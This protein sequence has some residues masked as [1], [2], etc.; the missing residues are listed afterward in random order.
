MESVKSLEIT[1]EILNLIAEIDEF[2]G[3][4]RA[5]GN[6]SPDTLLRLQ[7]VAAIESIAS[8][9]RIE[10][11]KLSGREVEQLLLNLKVQKFSTRDEQEVAGYA[12][13]MNTIFQFLRIRGCLK[14]MELKNSAKSCFAAWPNS[15]GSPMERTGQAAKNSILFGFDVFVLTFETAPTR[16][17]VIE[18]LYNF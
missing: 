16:S 14:S 5:L 9:T 3:A 1:P 18:A 10:G 15:S 11:S 6:L 17:K 12:D 7:K 4:W 13:L 8:S 2:K